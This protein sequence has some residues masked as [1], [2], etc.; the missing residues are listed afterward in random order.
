MIISTFEP[1]SFGAFNFGDE[2]SENSFQ[3]H[4][5]TGN[6]TPNL[7]NLK[8]KR[9]DTDETMGFREDNADDTDKKR[10]AREEDNDTE[11]VIPPQR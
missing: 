1:G 5:S 2:Q 3:L 6:V 4:W 11:I 7:I 9:I 10:K 8:I